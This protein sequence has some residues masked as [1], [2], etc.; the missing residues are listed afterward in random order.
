MIPVRG[1]LFLAYKHVKWHFLSVFVT[2]VATYSVF[3]A[4]LSKVK[5]AHPLSAAINPLWP[6]RLFVPVLT[7]LLFFL[8]DTF[9]R[10]ISSKFHA[11]SVYYPRR[12][13]SIC[14]SRFL[15]IFLFG[16]CNLPK[17][18]GY[19]TIFHH[20]IIYA[21]LVLIFALSHGYCTSLNMIYAPRRVNT[22]LSGTVGALMMMVCQ[23]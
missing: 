3:P 11:P 2:F 15:F 18:E 13:F 16:F 17:R 19:P 6:N 12:L 23:S 20:D 1:R 22:N 5:S 8:G 14:L 7:F 9:G 10:M 4:Y 21:S